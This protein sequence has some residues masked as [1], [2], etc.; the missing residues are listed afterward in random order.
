MIRLH[1]EMRKKSL[2]ERT[3]RPADRRAETQRFGPADFDQASVGLF[4]LLAQKAPALRVC[5]VESRRLAA[6][7]RRR[8]SCRW[9]CTPTGRWSA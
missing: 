6:M 8:T 4:L 1:S 2:S 3:L 7:D 5:L 9:P